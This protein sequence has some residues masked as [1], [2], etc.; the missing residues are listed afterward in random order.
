MPTHG[1]HQS[2]KAFAGRVWG[3]LQI[4]TKDTQVL[5]AMGLP[6]WGNHLIANTGRPA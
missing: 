2:A 5:E 3:L 4:V 1:A 6:E